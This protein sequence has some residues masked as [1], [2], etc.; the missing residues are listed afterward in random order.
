MRG[1]HSN[2]YSVVD[3][4]II[5]NSALP[6]K[7][8]TP[9]SWQGPSP[10]LK[11]LIK[12]D[13]PRTGD[14][15]FRVN[16]SKG[17]NSSSIE[18]LINLRENSPRLDRSG[19]VTISAKIKKIMVNLR[20]EGSATQNFI[21]KDNRWLMPKDFANYVWTEFNYSI[22][23][24]GLYQIDLVHPYVPN[25]ANPS[26]RISIL[27]KHDHGIVSKRL[28]INEKYKDDYEIVTPITLAYL[29]EG[30][31]KGYIG[32]KFLLD[33][34]TLFSHPCQKMIH[35]QKHLK[36]KQELMI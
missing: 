1:S 25:D 33:L 29:S 28:V 12:E 2:R 20:K 24:S 14:F 10:N 17:Y 18:R 35:F 15:A 9:K 21:L 22:P 11:L 30:D 7:E 13:F 4:G 31:H 26:Y 5:L 27:G 8:V 23:K 19:A 6:A 16:A 36:M 32:G 3:E 34:V